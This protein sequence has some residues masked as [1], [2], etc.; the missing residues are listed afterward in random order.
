[1]T[2]GCEGPV[3]ELE[4]G[5]CLAILVGAQSTQSQSGT[6]GDFKPLAQIIKWWN[7]ILPLI[8]AAAALVRKQGMHMR[9]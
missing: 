3:V 7:V 1:M 9:R 8:F 6:C 4:D 2:T 5:Y